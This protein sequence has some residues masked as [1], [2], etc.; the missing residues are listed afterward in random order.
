MRF[1]HTADW[2]IGKKLHGYDLLQE[3]EQAI[4]Q[5]RQIAATEAVDA[6]VIAGDLYDRTVP[7]TD[8]VE[9]FNKWI[10]QLNLTDG[11]PLLAISGNHDSPIRLETGSAWF[12][13][14]EF[15]LRTKLAEAF[16]P[17]EF[18]DTQVFLLPYFEPIAARLYFEQEYK[19]IQAAITDVLAEMKQ[20]FDPAKAHVLV[21]HF[22]VSGSSRTDSETTLTIGGL[23]GISLSALEDFDYV[24][25]GHLHGKDALKAERVRYSGSP[26]KYSLSERTQQKGVW[27]VD[28]G[29]DHFDC[30]FR[31]ITPPKDIQLVTASFQEL[32]DPAYYELMQRD[33]FLAIQLTD[34]AVIPNMMNRLRAV[35]P[36]ILQVERQTRQTQTTT[37][38][39]PVQQLAPPALFQQF[40]TKATNE[41]LTATQ[42]DWLARG[43]AAIKEA[44]Q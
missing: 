38:A 8:A 40:F 7:A 22:F 21:T 26:L 1:L 19:T 4:Q 18:P 25:L 14:S 13:Q 10:Q 31:E 12:S 32:L 44:E 37:L 33:A 23:D 30:Q 34:R 9:L 42:S 29:P 5:I 39:Q 41:T 15:Y 6:I 24:A 28:V 27:I 20:Q 35:Y 2:H 16:Q 36:Y 11:W 17:I 43:L 3:Q